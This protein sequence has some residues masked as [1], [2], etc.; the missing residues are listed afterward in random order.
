MA[1]NTILKTIVAIALIVIAGITMGCIDDSTYE[2][3]ESQY[4]PQEPAYTKIYVAGTI[5]M[6]AY[7]YNDN[8]I[9]YNSEPF[10][11][12]MPYTEYDWTAEMSIEEM[13]DLL[14]I[15]YNQ[16]DTEYETVERP[17]SDKLV[18]KGRYVVYGDGGYVVVNMYYT[19]TRY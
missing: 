16:I 15:P 4:E 19:G 18:Y 13:F 8:Y 10:S 7:D 6:T 5:S 3:S 14:G 1:I 11:E 9:G 12:E 2:Q 17:T